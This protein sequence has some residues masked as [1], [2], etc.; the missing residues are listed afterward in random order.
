M[1]LL[2]VNWATSSVEIDLIKFLD[3][4]SLPEIATSPE[5]Q[6]DGQSKICLE[7]AFGISNTA[8]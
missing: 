4:L 5:E 6:H 1:D 7:K 2:P 3:T 8:A